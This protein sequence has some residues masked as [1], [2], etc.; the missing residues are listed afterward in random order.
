MADK[1]A[2]LKRIHEWHDRRIMPPAA[3]GDK[4]IAVAQSCGRNREVNVSIRR[5]ISVTGLLRY[6]GE[7]EMLIGIVCVWMEL[8]NG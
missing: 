8:E 7:N 2:R 1:V 6:N 3:V 4:L 5:K